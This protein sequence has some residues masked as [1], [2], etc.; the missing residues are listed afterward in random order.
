[1]RIFEK[2]MAFIILGL[3]LGFFVFIFV[4]FFPFLG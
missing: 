1:M 4:A 2:I 3:F